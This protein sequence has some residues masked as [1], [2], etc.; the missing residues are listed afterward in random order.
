MWCCCCF[1][2]QTTV[3]EL[4]W[5][6]IAWQ[7]LVEILLKLTYYK[8][9]MLYSLQSVRPRKKEKTTKNTFTGRP[10]QIFHFGRIFFS[11]FSFSFFLSFFLFFFFFFLFFQNLVKLAIFWPKS[12]N[13]GWKLL[14]I[15]QNIFPK[16]FCQK[17]SDCFYFL[18][19]FF[20]FFFF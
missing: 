16:L 11:L 4:F 14:K 13:F 7:E 17:L 15:S 18:S 8:G 20:F 6:F 10:T 2:P 3:F 12:K 19:F 1:D 9:A 5:S